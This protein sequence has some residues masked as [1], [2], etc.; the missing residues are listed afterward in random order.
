MPGQCVRISTGAP[1]P[2]AADCVVWGE[3]SRLIQEADD[4]KSEMEIEIILPPE[5]GQ[6]IGTCCVMLYILKVNTY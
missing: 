5:V 3:D 1:L 6:D 2:K 4:G